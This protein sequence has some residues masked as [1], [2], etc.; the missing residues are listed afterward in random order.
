MATMDAPGLIRGSQEDYKRLYYSDPM[1][2]LKV[3]VTLQAAYGILKAGT[4]LSINKSAAGGVGKFLPYN[5]TTITGAENAPGRAYLVQ[6]SGTTA[7]ELYVT[8]D[9]SYKF[10]VGD[11]AIINDDTTAAENLG[12]IT[13]IDRATYSHMAKITVTSATG[14]TDF[15]T[16]R[17]A[18]LCVEAG[19]NTNA[20]SDCVGILEKSVDTGTGENANGALATLIL[21][22]CVLYTGVLTNMDAAAITDVSAASIGNYTYIK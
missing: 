15:T 22:N 16:A 10:A 11:D 5:P 19:D 7:T 4:A 13:A 21:G 9:D 3:P 1:A 14:G 12:A 8:M 18:Y 2:S 17:F 6:N 20:Y